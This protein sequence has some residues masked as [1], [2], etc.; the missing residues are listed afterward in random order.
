MRHGFLLV[1]KP[2]GPTSHDIVYGVRKR[3]NERDIGHLGTLDPA[4]SG[5]L[6]LA[7]GAKALKVIELFSGL[8]KEYEA[9]ITFGAISTTYDSAGVID[10]IEQKPGWSVPDI[11]ILN[12]TIEDRFIG[13][14]EQVPPAHSAIHVD[15]KRAYD[16]ARAGNAI[17]MKPRNVTIEQCDV[18]SYDYPHLKLNIRCSSGTYIRSLAHD[19]GHLLRCGAYLSGL[20]RTRV[21]E[22]SVEHAVPPEDTKWSDI[23]PLKDIMAGFPR[24]EL[25]DEEMRDISHGKTMNRV[26]DRE[27]IAW[28][29]GYP[30]A[31]LIPVTKDGKT[32][33][34][35]RKVF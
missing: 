7:V 3:L 30:V 5:L 2:V 26:S 28:Y 24:M 11:P 10:Q 13:N 4:A 16:L 19:L 21:G 6:V 27:S 32:S 18:V 35:P 33:M 34:R 9:D 23:L 8:P 15:G 25:N 1:D 20:R 29:D 22:W 14:I 12:R 17:S 31:I